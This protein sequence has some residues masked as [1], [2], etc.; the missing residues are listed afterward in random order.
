MTAAHARGRLRAARELLAPPGFD[1]YRLTPRKLLNLWLARWEEHRG[2]TRLRSRPWKLTVEA[3][4][5]CNL[6]CPA[7]FTGVDELGRPRGSLPVDLYRK[8]LDELG[9]YLFELEFYNW[10]EPLLHKQ[11]ESMIA[12]A[13]GRGISTTVSTNFSLPF[14]AARAERLVASGLAVLGVSIDGARQETYEQY[15]VRGKLAR[16]LDNCRLV[17]D[18]KR[19]LGSTTPRMVWEFHVFE[20]NEG[21][22]AEASRL[23]RELGMEIAVSKGWTVGKEWN[24]ASE[25]RFFWYPV[26]PARCSFLWHQAVVNNDGGVAP[27]CGTFYQE[28]DMGRLAVGTAE[29]GTAATFAE[30]WNGERFRTA[31]ALF[32]KRAGGDDA[33]ALACFECPLTKVWERW[34][35]HRGLGGTL[36]GFDPGYGTNDCFN[37]F[38][39][40]RPARPASARGGAR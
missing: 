7:C 5:L 39:E 21:D 22:V 33:R 18:A 20:H 13:T 37:Y 11:L 28:D 10:G 19:R 17:A 25:Y 4:N 31:R 9:P 6:Q 1:R 14:D 30:I 32:Q 40:R 16:V 24:P 34:G 23:A 38:W 26:P 2:R 29:L 3:S 27:C 8:L 36:G 12:E 15:R 35:M